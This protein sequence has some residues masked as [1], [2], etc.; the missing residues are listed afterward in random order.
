MPAAPLL[1]LLFEIRVKVGPP[2]LVG[3]DATTGRRQLIPILS[4]EL[5]GDS[6]RG[7]VL[8]GGVDSQV[9][10]PDGTCELSA[11]YGI[12]LDDGSRIYVENNGIRTVPAEWVSSVVAGGFVDPSLYYFKTVPRFEVFDEKHQWLTKRLVICSAEREPA[13]VSLRFYEVL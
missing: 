5:V 4:G 9:I 8:P 7:T 3:Q 10:R 12:E 11:R 1:S 6:F 2:I 13:W